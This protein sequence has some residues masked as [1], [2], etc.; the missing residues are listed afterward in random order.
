MKLFHPVIILSSS[1]R[2]PV[3]W[4]P[5]VSEGPG[6]VMA[7]D[8]AGVRTGG[9]SIIL[10]SSHVLPVKKIIVA[11]PAS[12]EKKSRMFSVL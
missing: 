1:C 8:K 2:H 5:T 4:V 3:L 12:F 9:A 6:F 10:T 11:G 7:T